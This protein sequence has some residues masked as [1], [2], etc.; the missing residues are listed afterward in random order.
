MHDK[1]FILSV[2]KERSSIIDILY[3]D[4]AL[5]DKRTCRSRRRTIYSPAP[6][7]D[8]EVLTERMKFLFLGN[9]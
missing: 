3:I 4:K 6:L 9:H 5:E 8:Q 7:C 1:G 2:T